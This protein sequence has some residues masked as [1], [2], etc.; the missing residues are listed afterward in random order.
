MENGIIVE[1]GPSGELFANP[2]E[3]RTRDFLK[4]IRTQHDA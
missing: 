4:N 2:R 1:Q 3:Q